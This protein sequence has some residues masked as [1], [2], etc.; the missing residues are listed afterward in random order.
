VET[1]LA[2]AEHDDTG[3]EFEAE[4]LLTEAGGPV[5]FAMR[6]YDAE[7]CR[8]LASAS[9]AKS[10]YIALL[11]AMHL[12]FVYE[13]STNREAAEFVAGQR[14]LVVRLRKEL[15]VSK[16]EADKAYALMQWCDAMSLLIC[17]HVQ[18]PEQRLVEI[19][20]GPDKRSYQLWE[21]RRGVLSVEPWPFAED[22][23]GV[24]I[25][26][27]LVDRLSFGSSAEFR[28]VL[29]AA[30]VKESRY[31]LKAGPRRVKRSMA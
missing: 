5:H 4:N 29:A 2:I 22:S 19:S 12:I 15:G 27:R 18:Q 11:S 21:P 9:M 10:R 31:L 28:A 20:A 16:R 7:H 1:V 24:N 3:V 23:F 14:E 8:K 17:Q 13:L 30:K 25:E 26:S 6:D